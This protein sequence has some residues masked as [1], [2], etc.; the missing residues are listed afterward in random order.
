MSEYDSTEARIPCR[1]T[2]EV[3]RLAIQHVGAIDI[4]TGERNG[5]VA[6]MAVV[7]EEDQVLLITEQGMIL[8]VPVSSIP[9]RGRNILGVRVVRVEEADRVVAAIKLVEKE[10]TNGENGEEPAEDEPIH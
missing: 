9:I 7:F 8:R 3:L 6:G 4:K 5:K 2:V 10:E 1:T